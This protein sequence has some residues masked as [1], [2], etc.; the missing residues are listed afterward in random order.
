MK[1]ALQFHIP[2]RFS[3]SRSILGRI[4]R[5]RIRDPRQ[6]ESTYIVAVVALVCFGAMLRIAARVILQDAI[7]ADP[8]GNVAVLFFAA[9]VAAILVFV[10]IGLVGFT[11]PILVELSDNMRIT[12]GSDTLTIDRSAVGVREISRELYH[13][14]YR[15][16]S[17][18][19]SF[20]ASNREPHLLLI[21][22]YGVTGSEGPVVLELDSP[23]RATFLR[24][25][26]RDEDRR[27]VAVAALPENADAA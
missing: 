10:V 12:R 8:T 14:H 26:V 7:R 27:D 24:A 20:V 1:P 17:A 18:T 3:A 6:A 5:R 9:E 25:F 11:E 4:I 2:R 16:F 13:T 21:E 19:R 23:S 22:A 15:R